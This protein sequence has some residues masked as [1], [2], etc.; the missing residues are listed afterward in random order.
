MRSKHL[1]SSDQQKPIDPRS[2]DQQKSRIKRSSDQKE[3]NDQRRCD[4]QKSSD[5]G[6]CNQQKP[7]DST[8]SD[9]QKSNIR[10]S[11]KS[12]NHHISDDQ[13]SGGEKAP[14]I[15]KEQTDNTILSISAHDTV[16]TGH[17][18]Q[19]SDLPLKESMAMKES[20]APPDESPVPPDDS[21]VPPNDQV[22]VFVH[23]S[24][25]EGEGWRSLAPGQNV[26]VKVRL[27]NK[28]NCY[29]NKDTYLSTLFFLNRF[30]QLPLSP[31]PVYCRI[32]SVH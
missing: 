14:T 7:N 17:H 23:Q 27:D 19:E 8:S 28:Y 15:G 18:S 24:V 30:L 4:Q 26:L 12:K 32:D 5:Q 25:I 6:S 21:T 1:E 10:V 11:Q 9:Q 3:S 13:R 16:N 2:S 20:T 22:D 31:L 29:K